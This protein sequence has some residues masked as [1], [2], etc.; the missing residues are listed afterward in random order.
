MDIVVSSPQSS[1]YI[2]GYPWSS[3]FGTKYSNPGSLPDMGSGGG[4]AFSP[5]GNNILFATFG[6]GNPPLQA[7]SWSAGFGTKYSDPS[8][9]GS[10]GLGAIG[11]VAF[12][13]SGDAVAVGTGFVSGGAAVNVFPWT[14]I[15]GFGSQYSNPASGP[16]GGSGIGNSVAWSPSGNAIVIGTDSTPYVQGWPWSAGFGTKYSAPLTTP[17]GSCNGVAFS[18]DGAYLAIASQGGVGVL[19]L[20]V[21]PW[22]SGFGDPPTIPLSSVPTG[23]GRACAWSPD[24]AYVAVA[25]ETAGYIDSYGWSAGFDGTHSNPTS[26]GGTGQAVAFS[27]DGAVLAIGCVASPYVLAYA[28]SGGFGSKYTDPGT[29]PTNPVGGLAFTPASPPPPPPPTTHGSGGITMMGVG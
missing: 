7:Y 28:F 13:P 4:V 18:P 23:N 10:S 8:A 15:T 27:S 9:V 25:H 3:G 24:G 2:Q 6:S 11:G 22:S 16:A 5:D 12:S 1:P 19:R 21:Y 20:A 29:L 26:P 14:N 17:V